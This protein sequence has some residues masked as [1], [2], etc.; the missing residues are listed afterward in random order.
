VRRPR[1]P[2]PEAAGGG[3]DPGPA[4]L[5]LWLWRARF[6]RTRALAA[7]AADGVRINGRRTGRPG[8]SVRPGDVLTFA[9]AGRIRVVEVLAAGA[10]RGPAPEARALY[11]DREPPAADRALRTLEG[12]GD[13][14]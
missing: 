8:A 7:A 9:Q 4:R 11:A 5:D 10:R 3:G 6:F 12:G 13:A 1:D 2:A 14:S